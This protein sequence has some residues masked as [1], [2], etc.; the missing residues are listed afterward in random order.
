M[1]FGGVDQTYKPLTNDIRY[2]IHFLS[3]TQYVLSPY[4]KFSTNDTMI[5]LGANKKKILSQ[6][7]C[8][9]THEIPPSHTHVFKR[10]PMTVIKP[11]PTFLT[12]S[13]NLILLPSIF[14][15]LP[16]I[17]PCHRNFGCVQNFVSCY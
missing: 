11:S 15:Y 13:L 12:S 3:I 17:C 4:I 8:Q 10:Q 5:P 9:V 2:P 1:Y 6:N 14:R 16:C 7:G